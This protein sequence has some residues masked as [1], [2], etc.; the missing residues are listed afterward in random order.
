[1]SVWN[2][3]K[4]FYAIAEGNE[5]LIYLHDRQSYAFSM[6]IH[7]SRVVAM[8]WSPSD[9][10]LAAVG[11]DGRVLVWWAQCSFFHPVYQS[12]NPDLVERARL[13][14]EQGMLEQ[15]MTAEWSQ[16]ESGQ[17]MNM[18]MSDGSTY[19]HIMPDI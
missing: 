12:M 16:V 11:D 10:Y 9:K 8:A 19:T 3:A 17:Q 4:T 18:T 5:V 1:M 7:S 14:R 2:H 15:A 6:H 13:V